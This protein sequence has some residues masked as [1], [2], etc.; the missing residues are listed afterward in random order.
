MLRAGRS[1]GR[2][3]IRARSSAPHALRVDRDAALSEAPGGAAG[4]GADTADGID[5]RAAAMLPADLLHDD[6]IIILMLRPSALYIVLNSLTSLAF[7]GFITFLLA[8]VARFAMPLVM[9]TDAEAFVI[10]G[11][12][13]ALRLAWQG[14]DWYSRVYVLTDR[15]IIR[16][17]GVFR[18]AIFQAELKFIQHTSVFRR[19]RERIFSLGTIGFATAGSDVYE[20]FWVMIPEPFKIHKIVVDAIRRYGKPG[21]RI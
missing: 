4:A 5:E 17:M 12:L 11:T 19:V 13:I 18:V 3:T 9:W 6:E 1:F 16:R 10:G 7:L 14:L 21:K 8:Y 2:R 15:R 20:A